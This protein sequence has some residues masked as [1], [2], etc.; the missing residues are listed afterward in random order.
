MI[1]NDANTLV[2]NAAV[3]ASLNTI[4]YIALKNAGGEYFRKAYASKTMI[5]ASK[6]Q[7]TFFIDTSE[8]NDTITGLALCGNGATVTLNSGT[9]FATQSLALVKTSAQ[10]FSIVWTVELV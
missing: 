8:G 6:A 4:N 7:Y 5:S 10:S 2:L 1:T 3:A 9:T